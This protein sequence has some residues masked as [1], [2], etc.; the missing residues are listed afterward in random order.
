MEEQQKVEGGEQEEKELTAKEKIEVQWFG[1]FLWIIFSCYQLERQEEAKLRQKFPTVGRPSLPGKPAGGNSYFH[2]ITCS[3]KIR[4]WPVLIWRME[5]I[6]LSFTQ[7]AI[8]NS[9]EMWLVLFL[10]K[11]F[12]LGP[13]GQSSFL[14]KRM[15]K[16]TKYFDSGDYQ[17]NHKNIKSIVIPQ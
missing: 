2:C 10:I 11:L 13:G 1:S 7:L 12:H 17:V 15:A 16:N 3:L 9:P 4:N 14:Q 8:V 6:L 5:K